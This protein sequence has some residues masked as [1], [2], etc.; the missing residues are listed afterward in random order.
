MERETLP[1][2]IVG[3][4]DHGKSTLIGRL[5]CDTGSL[6]AGKMEEI[7]DAARR[8]GK[9]LEYGFIMDHLREERSRGITID[10][11]QT[12]FSSPKRDYVIIDAPG[13]KEFTKNMVTGASQAQ[14][15]VLICSVA[16]GVQEQTRRHA[17]LLKMLGI[18]QVMVA[19]NKMD[20]VGYEEAAFRSVR[21]QMNEFLSRIGISPGIEVPISAREGDNVASRSERMSWYDGPSVVGALDLFSKAPPPASRPLRFPVQDVYTVDHEGREE[22][23]AVGRVETGVLKAGERLRFLP[24]ARELTVQAVRQYARGDLAEAGPGMCVGVLFDADPPDRGAVGCPLDGQAQVTDCFEASVFWLSPAPLRPEKEPDGLVLKVATQEQPCRVVAVRER[25]DSG[26]LERLR[27]EDAV[28]EEMQVGELT[29]QTEGPVVLESF[30]DV[31]E[32]GRFVLVRGQDVVAGGI[33]TVPCAR[34]PRTET[35]R[36]S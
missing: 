32:L 34:G 29:I 22:R 26:T 31:Q 15:A 6:P 9:K 21:A 2:V 24:G 11:A 10:T 23:I 18:E 4:V 13:H 30:Y 16:E 3:H 25:L 17:Y 14:A 27:V 33:V 19:Y 8:E 28:L 1:L 7:E 35:G 12:F 5:L 36:A 20:L